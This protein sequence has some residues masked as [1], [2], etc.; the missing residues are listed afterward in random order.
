MFNAFADAS[1]RSLHGETVV[2]VRHT[3]PSQECIKLFQFRFYNAACRKCVLWMSSALE[4]FCVSSSS[5]ETSI[6]FKGNEGCLP[7]SRSKGRKSRNSL[8]CA[9]DVEKLRHHKLA[10]EEQKGMVRP[11]QDQ[12]LSSSRVLCWMNSLQLGLALT[13]LLIES[14]TLDAELQHLASSTAGLKSS[15]EEL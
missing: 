9:V 1:H 7:V 4:S 12:E 15:S 6:S 11:V 10:R 3:V 5:S 13:K 2:Y 8:S 14:S